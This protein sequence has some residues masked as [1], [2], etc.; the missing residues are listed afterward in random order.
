MVLAFVFEVVWY[1]YRSLDEN[2]VEDLDTDLTFAIL[3]KSATKLSD[4]PLIVS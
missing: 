4:R 1:S 3:D 2:A